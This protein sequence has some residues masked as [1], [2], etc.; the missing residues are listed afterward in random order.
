MLLTKFRQEASDAHRQP[1]P[2]GGSGSPGSAD[3]VLLELDVRRVAAGRFS[4]AR[5]RGRPGAIC[6]GADFLD[7]FGAENADGSWRRMRAADGGMVSTVALPEVIEPYTRF[8]SSKRA[9]PAV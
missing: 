2:A 8:R 7:R 1:G 3:E 6:A 5:A 9:L 4:R